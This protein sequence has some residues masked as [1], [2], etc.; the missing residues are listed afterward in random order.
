MDRVSWLAG[1]GESKSVDR[2]NSFFE[3]GLWIFL[4]DT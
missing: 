4:L 2:W 1:G 3:M